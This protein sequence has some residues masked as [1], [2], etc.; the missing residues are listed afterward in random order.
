MNIYTCGNKVKSN[1][2]VIIMY[3]SGYGGG[4]DSVKG[5]NLEQEL[6]NQA[7]VEIDKSHDFQKHIISCRILL[8]F[9]C[10]DGRGSKGT[11]EEPVPKRNDS[12]R[13]GRLSVK[14]PA[15]NLKK[16]ERVTI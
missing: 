3:D 8:A 9:E 15:R 13:A 14:A 1:Y 4:W 12:Y 11:S 7:G 6:R 2:N 10:V 5:V 16:F